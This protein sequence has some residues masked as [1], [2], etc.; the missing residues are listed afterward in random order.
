MWQQ[1]KIIIIVFISGLQSSLF[2]LTWCA[3]L[4]FGF[5]LYALWFMFAFIKNITIKRVPLFFIFPRPSF[6]K[7]EWLILQSPRSQPGSTLLELGSTRLTSDYHTKVPLLLQLWSILYLKK[8]KDPTKV[9]P[10][11]VISLY[12]FKVTLRC[13]VMCKINIYCQKSK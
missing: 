1:F 13:T 8:D 9:Q 5:E 10:V 4:T 6:Q 3:S 11:W 12:G 2:N 7:S